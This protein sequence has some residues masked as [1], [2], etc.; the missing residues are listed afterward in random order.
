MLIMQR[1]ALLNF[2]VVPKSQCFS[3][4][5]WYS[6]ICSIS[7]STMYRSV[8]VSESKISFSG[9][10]TAE[11]NEYVYDYSKTTK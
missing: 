2:V 6:A 4:Y 9:L 3:R 8:W 1:L 11:D 7:Q 5:R 10:K